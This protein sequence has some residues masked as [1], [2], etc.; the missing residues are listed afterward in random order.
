MIPSTRKNSQNCAK[1]THD[2]VRKCKC[3]RIS[4]E[5]DSNIRHG[6]LVYGNNQ[7]KSRRGDCLVSHVSQSPVQSNLVVQKLFA[8]STP[9]WIISLNLSKAFDWMRWDKID[10]NCG[11]HCGYMA[12]LTTWCRQ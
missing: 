11:L 3:I 4:Q 10:I 1:K 8:V 2:L 9:V 5:Y 7:N 12:S 6:Y